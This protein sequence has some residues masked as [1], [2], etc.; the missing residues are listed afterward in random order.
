MDV[1]SGVRGGERIIHL[2][3]KRVK[4]L[5]PFSGAG[6]SSGRSEAADSFI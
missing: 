2:S 6:T 1:K 5:V 4:K 3:S